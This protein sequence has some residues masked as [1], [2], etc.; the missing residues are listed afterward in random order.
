MRMGM[1]MS[2]VVTAS[3]TSTTSTTSN[4]STGSIYC[5]RYR[6]P[7]LYRCKE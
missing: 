7:P 1:N 2:T 5:K 6:S 4:V 3:T